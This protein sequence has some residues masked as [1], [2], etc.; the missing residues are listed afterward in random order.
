M[1]F[2]ERLVS[3]T[4]FVLYSILGESITLLDLHKEMRLS[5]VEK[6]FLPGCNKNDIYCGSV[7]QV[8]ESI[9]FDQAEK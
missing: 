6:I 2:D 5:L 1:N 9:R 3:Q 4:V 8:R 7:P